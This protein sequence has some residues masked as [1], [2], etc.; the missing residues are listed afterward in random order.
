MCT[1]TWTESAAGLVVLCNR[2]ELRTRARA[3]PPTTRCGDDG[4]RYISPID[5]EAGGTWIAV[6]EQGLCLCLLNGDLDRAGLARDRAVSRGE[7][8]GHLIAAPEVAGAESRLDRLDLERYRPFQLLVAMH[9][10]GAAELERRSVAR[11]AI[12]DGRTLTWRSPGDVPSSHLLSSSSRDGARARRERL[13]LW[14]EACAEDQQPHAQFR[15]HRSH[16]PEKGP[17]SPCMHRE[18]A[19]TVS[20]TRVEIAPSEVRLAYAAGPACQAELGPPLALARRS[21][22]LG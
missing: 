3:K 19:Q 4:I 7:I 1:V 8:I 6:S 12:W 15:F 10:T 2:D 21:R 13:A 14:E 18:D 22:V 9:D 11:I 20:F 5:G 17:W 16:R